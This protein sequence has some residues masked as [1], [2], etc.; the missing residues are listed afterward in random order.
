LLAS[1]KIKALSLALIAA[2]LKTSYF[3]IQ[4]REQEHQA[5]I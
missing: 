3:Q 4:K 1:A 5:F 2:F